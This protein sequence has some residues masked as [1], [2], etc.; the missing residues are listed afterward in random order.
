KDPAKC[1][2]YLVEGNSAGGSAKMGR[3]REFQAILPLRGK[4]LNVEKARMDKIL[5]NQEIRN[6]I[7]A[8][9]TGIGQEFNL[10]NARYHRVVI[11]TDADVDGAHIRTL[12]LTLF[13]RYMKPLIE[14]GYIFIAQPPLYR[15]AKGNK[16]M[17]VYTEKERADAMAE[18]GRGAGIQRYKGL[19]EMNPK[20]LWE[21]TM[22]P[23]KRVMKQVSIEDAVRA[24][25]LFTVLMGDEVQPR[26]EFIITHA[27][28][29]ENLDI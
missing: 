19:G 5:K 22:D 21:T 4:V 1:E 17:Y 16:E 28:E 2:I 14:N 8:L 15:V 23:E 9:G 25:E 7:T 10:A 3:N 20:Q 6:L 11:M 13:F 18:L 24:D 27:K 12:L 26:K 29:V